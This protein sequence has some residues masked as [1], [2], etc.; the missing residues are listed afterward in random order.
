MSRDDDFAKIKA[1][2]RALKDKTVANGCTEEEAIAAAEKAAELLSKH[3]LTEADLVADA[4]DTS[5]HRVG[6]RSPLET[7]WVAT[8]RF[9]DCKLWLER[10][11]NGVHITFFGRAS[12]VLIA[13]YVHD[14]LTG[15]TGRAVREFRASETYRKRRTGKTRAHA[16]RAFQEGFARGVVRQ[17]DNGLWRRYGPNAEQM[18]SD[19]KRLLDEMALRRGVVLSGQCRPLGRAKGAFRDNARFDG[20]RAGKEVNVAAAV[21]TAVVAGLLG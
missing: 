10:S 11:T 1:R 17:L 15:A 20:Y 12:D 5:T 8:A 3:G 6:K 7:I 18:L 9:A 19:A 2:L 21:P 4:F 14:V 13:E 16:L